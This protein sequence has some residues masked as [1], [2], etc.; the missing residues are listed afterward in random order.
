MPADDGAELLTG[1]QVGGL[2]EA[3][4]RHAGGLLQEWELDHVDAQPRSSTTATY[5]ARVAWPRS[6]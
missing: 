1:P 3:A 4:V 5:A 2:L 6:A